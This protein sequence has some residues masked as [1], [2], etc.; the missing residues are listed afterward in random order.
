MININFYTFSKKDNSTKRPTGAGTVLSCNIKSRSSIVNPFIELKTNPTAFNY[1]YIPSFNRY[2][3]ISDITFDSGLWLV[4]CR[5]DVLATY[6]T[7]IGNTSMYVLRSSERSNG[8]IVDT[9]FPTTA[10]TTVTAVNPDPLSTLPGV[11]RFEDGFYIIGVQGIDQA[12]DNGVIY[13]QLTP[14]KF[15]LLL[16]TFYANSGNGA[17][18]GNLAR[19]VIDS[20]Y[21]ISDFITSCRWFPKS[22]VVDY[23]IDDSGP[24]PVPG[25]GY[26]IYLGGFNTHVKAPRVIGT[27]E[28]FTLYNDI[29]KHPQSAYGNY[30]KIYP[31]THYEMVDPLIGVITLNPV[32][33][34]NDTSVIM[35]VEFDYVSGDAKLTICGDNSNYPFYITYI[36]GSVDINLSGSNFDIAGTVGGIVGGAIRALTENPIGVIAGVGSTLNNIMP[37][38]GSN[39]S[40]GSMLA[41]DSYRPFIRCTFKQITARNISERGLPLMES[42]TPAQLGGYILPDEPHVEINGTAIEKDML[43]N[44]L[45]GG[46]HYD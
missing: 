6:K 4:T 12:S 3:Y 29:P 23:G 30:T 40:S 10:Y 44:A 19:G 28:Y 27:A 35:Y 38:P 5:I 17:W 33:M 7:E 22:M 13:Y 1:C 46:F 43:E 34:K 24:Q 32:V 15:T 16:H 8:E 9:L 45:R 41:F 2:Y 39:Q 25:D 14:A 20:I 21:H 31:Y 11:Y 18:W 36:K 26:E 42:R 37:A